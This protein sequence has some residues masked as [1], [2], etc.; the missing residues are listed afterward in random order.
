MVPAD[1]AGIVDELEVTALFPCFQ[2]CETELS[3]YLCV[4]KVFQF[5]N[6]FGGSCLDFFDG[7][8]VLFQVRSPDAYYRWGRTKTMLSILRLSFVQHENECFGAPTALALC[9]E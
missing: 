1:M 2:D 7:S 6:H 9:T 3:K 4:V 8:D 5:R